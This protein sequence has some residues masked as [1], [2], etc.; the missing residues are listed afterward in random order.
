VIVARPSRIIA[1]HLVAG[2][3]VASGCGDGAK[4]AAA[5]ASSATGDTS[6]RAIAM[7][8][9]VVIARPSQPY[10]VEAVATPGSVMGTVTTSASLEPA[11]PVS[12]GP[13]SAVCGAS[14]P[15]SSVSR[16]GS[17]L[18][19]V[20][21]WLDGVRRGKSL[22][23]ERRHELESIGCRLTPRVQAGVTQ[24]A[25]N[26]IGHDAFRQ[27]LRFVAG[28]ESEP[29]ASILLGKD[30]QV[31]P[32]ERPF[33]APG[34]VIVKD[35]DHSWPTAYIAVFDHPYFA[36]TA[37]NGSFTIDGVPPGTYTVRAWHERTARGEQVVEVTAGGTA[38]AD[39]ALKG[40]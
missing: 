19:G 5:S 10:V 35:A 7:P 29:R 3:L 21:V 15:D 8:T 31:I 34:L 12:T 6:A 33:S 18:G 39:L 32:T 14:I 2:L 27:H 36:V 28:G 25:V 13:D 40:K 4:P 11:D 17:S 1:L 20:V 16:Q 37:P 9:E 24:S 26:I 30:E 38:R 22:P 23:A